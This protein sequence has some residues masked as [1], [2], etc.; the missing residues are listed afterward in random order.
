MRVENA[1]DAVLLNSRDPN[2]F[3]RFYERH[4]S[5]IVSYLG[6]RVHGADVVFDLTAETFARAFERRAQYDPARGPGVA[7]V[8]VIARNLLIDSVRR[9]R[10]LD[11]SRRRLGVTPVAVDDAQLELIETRSQVDLRAVLRGLPTDQREAVI[12]RFL[13]EESYPEIAQQLSCSEQVVRKRVSRGLANARQA[14]EEQ[15]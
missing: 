11:E 8:L 13:L 2:D 15:P 10:V 7:W 14:V 3:G 1:D 4:V 12:R 9:S 5:A 6:P